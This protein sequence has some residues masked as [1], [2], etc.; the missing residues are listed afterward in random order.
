MYFDVSCG[1]C[2]I[3]ASMKTSLSRVQD[4]GVCVLIALLFSIT[5]E[6]FVCV[7]SKAVCSE[8][9]TLS[10]LPLAAV[11]CYCID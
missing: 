11:G 4:N 9:V 6:T 1:C 3:L 10:A 7:T 5:N 2:A 8:Y